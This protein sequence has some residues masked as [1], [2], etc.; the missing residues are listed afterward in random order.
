MYP[1]C[2]TKTDWTLSYI[3]GR[4]KFSVIKQS[5]AFR[6]VHSTCLKPPIGGF[7]NLAS[8]RNR[9]IHLNLEYTMA[10]ELGAYIIKL[11]NMKLQLYL[12]DTS[13]RNNNFQ[14]N[15]SH[16]FVLS[17]RYFHVYQTM[18]VLHKWK[19]Q[20]IH[21]ALH[22]GCGNSNLNGNN[23]FQSNNWKYWF[24]NQIFSRVSYYECAS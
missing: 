3:T 17:S 20:N 21:L 16:N 6:E 19:G 23:N 18:N 1:C 15:D 24:A 13:N 8:S 4:T 5:M 22:G 14:S 2:L 9:L 7:R 12:N 10:W 11:I